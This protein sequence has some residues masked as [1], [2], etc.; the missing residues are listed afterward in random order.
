[1]GKNPEGGREGV[2]GISGKVGERA[3]HLVKEETPVHTW[4]LHLHQDAQ[5]KN[6]REK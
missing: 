5:G 3:R 6:R 2:G 1:M 4:E